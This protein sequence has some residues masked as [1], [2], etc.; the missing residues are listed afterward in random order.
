MVKRQI[1]ECHYCIKLLTVSCHFVNHYLKIFVLISIGLASCLPPIRRIGI[2]NNS[3]TDLKIE[4]NP[5]ITYSG[6]PEKSIL[7]FSVDS[8]IWKYPG[9]GINAKVLQPDKGEH[10]DSTLA[11][12]VFLEYR[13]YRDKDINGIY[14]M[15]PFSSFEIGSTFLEGTITKSL[16]K[17][18]ISISFLKIY[19]PNGDT[20]VAKSKQEVWALLLKNKFRKQNK[21][22]KEL[23]FYKKYESVVTPLLVF[24]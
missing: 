11:L 12:P 3:K 4:T 23:K 5:I 15:R 9:L 17:E 8:I 16:S 6:G 22:N 19:L 14:L 2:I 21:L 24:S 13:Y 10:L 20:I 1:N 7:Y 18:N